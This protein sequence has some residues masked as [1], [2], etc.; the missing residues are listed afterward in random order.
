MNPTPIEKLEK[1]LAKEWGWRRKELTGFALTVFL[2]EEQRSPTPT[3]HENTLLKM[4]V[5]LLYS[6]W[7][8]FLIS[9]AKAY[10][11]FL[12]GENLKYR[13]LADSFTVYCIL[14]KFDGEF[15]KKF[16][17]YADAV[18][19]VN[20]GLNENLKINTGKH[21]RGKSNLNS[22]ALQD[23]LQKLGFSYTQYELQAN[24]IDEVFLALRN[25][26]AHGEQRML[27]KPEIKE[28]YVKVVNMMETFKD[29]IASSVQEKTYLRTHS[30]S[31]AGV[32]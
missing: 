2:S 28:L 32:N 16:G 9:A 27:N 24:L 5:V 31:A 20:G 8:G 29:Q 1:R 4:F 21:I 25:S 15:P 3:I 12:N 14:E 6:H 22:N 23:I 17:A 18:A 10:C 26:I 30:I 19:I 7:E 11:E 13:D